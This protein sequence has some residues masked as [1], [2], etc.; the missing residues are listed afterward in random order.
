MASTRCAGFAPQV[1]V[2]KLRMLNTWGAHAQGPGPG[3]RAKLAL[4]HWRT[5]G[6]AG[7]GGRLHNAFKQAMEEEAHTTALARYDRVPM[8]MVS[9]SDL[10]FAQ[11]TFTREKALIEKL[12]MAK[13][14]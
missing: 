3:H 14:Q 7:G 12:G 4:W 9:T 1:K 10:K 5:Q 8:Y 2:G 11:D 6:H 13:A